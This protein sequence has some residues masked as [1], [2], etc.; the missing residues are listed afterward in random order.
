LTDFQIHPLTP[1]R[2]DYF[3]HLFGPEKGENG[4]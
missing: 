4:G 2:W 3:E 1:D